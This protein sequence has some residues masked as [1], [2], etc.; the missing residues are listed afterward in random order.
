[1]Q[2]MAHVMTN[3]VFVDGEDVSDEIVEN[4]AK[5]LAEE[6]EKAAKNLSLRAIKNTSVGAI[7]VAEI[8]SSFPHRSK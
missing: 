8:K 6:L 2:F 5:H 3:I 1:M 7:Q 4:Y